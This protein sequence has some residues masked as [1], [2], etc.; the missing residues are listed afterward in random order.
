MARLVVPDIA[1]SLGT[2]QWLAPEVIDRGNEH[3]DEYSDIY[4]FG[5]VLWEICTLKIPFI[6]YLTYP[7]YTMDAW[8]KNGNEI[9]QFNVELIKV[10]IIEKNLRP[11][12]RKE[13]IPIEGIAE[14]ITQC[15]SATPKDRPTFIEIVERL[16]KISGISVN[17]QLTNDII[18][19]QS[20]NSLSHSSNQNSMKNTRSTTLAN[21]T[22]PR[23]SKSPTSSPVSTWSES[24]MKQSPPKTI[25][26]PS[27]SL[28][29]SITSATVAGIINQT[30]L[31]SSQVA[32][33]YQQQ[34]RPEDLSDCENEFSKFVEWQSKL[35]FTSKIRCL[36]IVSDTMWIGLDG[37]LIRIYHS[38]TFEFIKELQCFTNKVSTV[39]S[40]IIVEDNYVWC[41]YEDGW[42]IVWNIES[43]EVTKKW[44]AHPNQ[45][46]KSL[47]IVH[48]PNG[49]RVWSASPIEKVIRVWNVNDY[50]LIHTINEHHAVYC[51][52]QHQDYVWVGGNG[53]LYLYSI[54][55]FQCRGNWR[56]HESS[57][58]CILSL[59]N[60]VWTGSAAGSMKVWEDKVLYFFLPLL[61]FNYFFLRIFSPL[62]RIGSV[63]RWKWEIK[64]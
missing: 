39:H 47:L 2:W 35:E 11:T 43:Y 42:I 14:L 8:D 63:C 25:H 64:F 17:K 23:D 41:G 53:E 61:F 27:L 52:C 50:S 46:I 5:I 3:Y 21:S 7:E 58:T 38:S 22:T 59:G 29:S 30:N 28:T 55:N 10:A 18:P 9:K 6:E 44:E 16:S 12:I 15:F 37:G 33:Y 32:Y 36:M 51:L 13:R 40:M 1:G 54:S 45:V 24:S 26:S 56:V 31:P 62:D 4:S 19:T 57:I 49:K 60:R 48:T 20:S 34:I